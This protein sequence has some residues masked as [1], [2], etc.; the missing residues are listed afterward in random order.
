VDLPWQE[1]AAC[2]GHFHFLDYEYEHVAYETCY[3]CPV[4]VDC[5]QFAI[6]N[7]EELGI[8]GGLRYERVGIRPLNPRRQV[9]IPIEGSG[10]RRVRERR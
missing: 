9:Q 1:L 8:W 6:D 10:R 4:R 5:H 7:G 2:R 3:D